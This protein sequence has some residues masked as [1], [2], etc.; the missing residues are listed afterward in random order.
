[1]KMTLDLPSDLMNEVKQHAL[2]GG[3]DLDYA[4]A[5]LLRKGLATWGSSSPVGPRPVI[6]LHPQ[7]GLP[8]IECPSD[9]PARRK[10]VAELVALEHETQTQA[11][12]EQFGV[13]NRH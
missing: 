13:S 1:M 12:F 6:K 11:D 7:S 9:A 5:D 3:V 8:Y 4:T 2:Q 10:T